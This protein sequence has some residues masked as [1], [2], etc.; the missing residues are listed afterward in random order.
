M[1]ATP[2]HRRASR[3]IQRALMCAL[4]LLCASAHAQPV[5]PATAPLVQGE[6]SLTEPYDATISPLIAT[7]VTESQGALMLTSALT[8]TE[9]TASI[10]ETPELSELWQLCDGEAFP[11]QPTAAFC[12][13]TLI[14]ADLLLTAEHCVPNKRT[15]RAVSVVF[16]YRY[17]SDGVLAPLERDDVYACSRVFVSDSAGDYAIIQ[18]DRAVVGRTPATPRFMDPATCTG[19]RNGGHVW[20]AGFPSGVPLKIDVGEPGGGGSSTGVVV[21]EEG[22][23]GKRFFRAGFDLFA[24][25]DGGGVFTLVTRTVDG[26]VVEEAQLVGSLS[27]GRADYERTSA[28]CYTAVTVTDASSELAAHVIQPLISLCNKTGDYDDDGLC[29]ATV[30][31]CPPGNAVEG[32]DAGMRAFPPQQGC[33]CRVGGDAPTERAAALAVIGLVAVCATRRSRRRAH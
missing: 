1:K 30:S 8:L 19:V 26:G 33:G 12:G 6:F 31:R 10:N 13:G 3:A 17:T 24:G 7:A 18:L 32:A 4:S 29:P 14:A 2:S 16:D 25:M 9:T 21:T 23:S 20:A 5:R 15:C 28:G 27:L 11:T 22:V